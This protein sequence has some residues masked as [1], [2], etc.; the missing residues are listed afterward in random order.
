VIRTLQCLF[1]VVLI[2]GTAASA[3]T[4]SDLVVF[5]DSLSDAGNGFALN[6]QP[7][8]P[9]YFQGRASDGP[10]WVERLAPLIGVAVPTASAVG[11]PNASDYAYYNARTTGGSVPSVQQQVQT[12][13]AGHTPSP[14]DL[15]TIQGGA[16][17]FSAGVLDPNA[18]AHAIGN[19]I[20]ALIGA[21]AKHVLVMNLPPLGQTPAFLGTPLEGFATSLSDSYDAT[22]AGDLTTLRST[23][24]DVT[25][26]LLDADALFRRI[27]ADPAAY[28]LTDVTHPALTGTPPM[29]GPDAD[30][31]LFWDTGHPTATGH[32]LLAEAAASE[33]P[34]PA[35]LPMILIAVAAFIR[36][37]IRAISG[38]QAA[39][40]T[41]PVVTSA[42]SS[43]KAGCSARSRWRSRE[44]SR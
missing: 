8:S 14:G 13:L 37:P 4:F 40:A 33:V 44:S 39:T 21:G 27:I 30:Q 42:L 9:P 32:Q 2:A 25:I 1:G 38:E 5:G 34:E 22:F 23:H 11:G 6:G 7:P 12:Y 20:S 41:W 3:G 17:D 19:D 18:P 43:H 26:S 10:V 16:D 15:F 29:A 24:P 28:G 35:V 36:R 31:H